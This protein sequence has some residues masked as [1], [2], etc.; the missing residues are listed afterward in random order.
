MTSQGILYT[1][2]TPVKKRDAMRQLSAPALSPIQATLKQYRLVV[3]IQSVTIDNELS[4]EVGPLVGRVGSVP[5]LTCISTIRIVFRQPTSNTFSV[6]LCLSVC[7][8]YGVAILTIRNCSLFL[9]AVHG[10]CHFPSARTRA[11]SR[12]PT[13]QPLLQPQLQRLLRGGRVVRT[14]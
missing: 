6:Y 12:F 13:N 3:L 8:H 9:T 10:L 14:R 4:K 2:P 7:V 5:H 1:Y 11:P